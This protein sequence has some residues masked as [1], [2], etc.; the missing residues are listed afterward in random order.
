MSSSGHLGDRR[1]SKLGLDKIGI[2]GIS[3][4]GKTTLRNILIEKLN[5]IEIFHIDDYNS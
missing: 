2:G 1:N 3:R 4:S 5:P